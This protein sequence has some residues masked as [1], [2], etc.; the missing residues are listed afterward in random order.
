MMEVMAFETSSSLFS[1]GVEDGQLAPFHLPMCTLMQDSVLP[2]E[3]VSPIKLFPTFPTFLWT[4]IIT[5]CHR[6]LNHSAQ[7]IVPLLVA[8]TVDNRVLET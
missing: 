1:L 3:R 6:T 5:L 7:L 2:Q 8:F 4:A